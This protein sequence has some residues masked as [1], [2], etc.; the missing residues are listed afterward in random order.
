[1][2]IAVRFLVWRP[3]IHDPRLTLWLKSKSLIARSC[4]RPISIAMIPSGENCYRLT[5]GIVDQTQVKD[6]TDGFVADLEFEQD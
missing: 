3:E 6:D 5:P 2:P 4:R 1:M